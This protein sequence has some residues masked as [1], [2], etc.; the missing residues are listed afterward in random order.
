M[1][2]FHSSY[3]TQIVFTFSTNE[4][5]Q[6]EDVGSHLNNLPVRDAG[7]VAIFKLSCLSLVKNI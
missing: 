5:E 7:K 1:Q 3:A 4:G 6:V 2:R